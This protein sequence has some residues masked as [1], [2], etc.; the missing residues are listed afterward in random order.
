MNQ[1]E[2]DEW[3]ACFTINFDGAYVQIWED[4]IQLDGDFYISDLERL[5]G[6]MKVEGMT[7]RRPMR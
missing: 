6:F 4:T 3:S 2:R 7:K 5:V 1:Q